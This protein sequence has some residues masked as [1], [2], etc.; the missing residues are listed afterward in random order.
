MSVY[1]AHPN[2]NKT[3]VEYV[4]LSGPYYQDVVLGSLPIPFQCLN[5]VLD[6]A[7]IDNFDAYSGQPLMN[8]DVGATNMSLCKLIGGTR[9]ATTLGSNF[10]RYIRAWRPDAVGNPIKMVVAPIMTRVQISSK[11]MLNTGAVFKTTSTPPS[12]DNY[13]FGDEADSY[14]TLWILKTPLTISTIESGVL[15]YITFNTTLY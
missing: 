12:G 8:I 5:G 13:V 6:I 4:R 11:T 10:L 15:V 14:R 1:R 7:H 3:P 2:T 9:V